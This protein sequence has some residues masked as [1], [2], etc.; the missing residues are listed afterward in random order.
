MSKLDKVKIDNLIHKLGLKYQ[1]PDNVIKE[2][3]ESPYKFTL[4]KI[5][6]LEL[7]NIETEEELNSIK[8]NFIYKGLYK[9]YIDFASVKRRKQ[10]KNNLIKRHN[11]GGIK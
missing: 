11:N 8:T 1:L 3:V 4:E 5:K 10:Q 2:I 6:E 9:M 7:S